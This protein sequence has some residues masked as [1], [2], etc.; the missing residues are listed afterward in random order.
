MLHEITDGWILRKGRRQTR[1][2]DDLMGNSNY[3]TD[4]KNA[5][6]DRRSVWQTLLEIF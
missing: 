4:L 2:I 3:N 5:A 1:M 6:D